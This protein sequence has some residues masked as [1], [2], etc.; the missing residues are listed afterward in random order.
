[1]KNI[2]DIDP[3]KITNFWNATIGERFPLREQLWNQ[4]TVTDPNILPQASFAVLDEDKLI[5]ILVSKKYQEQHQNLYMPTETGWIQCLLVDRE[6]RG[7]GIGTRLLSLAEKTFQELK[8]KDIKIGRDPQHYFPG[9]PFEDKESI[10]FFENKG[11]EKDSIEIDLYKRV[12]DQSLYELNHHESY[13]RLLS[14]HDHD[15]LLQFLQVSFP[16]RWH[17]EAARYFAQGGSGRE[18]LGLFVNG[19]MKGF[20]RLHDLDSPFIAANLYWSPLLEGKSGGIG[21][22]GVDRS[23]RGQNLGL[24]IVKAAANELIKRGMDHIIIDWTQLEQFYGKMG[25]RPWK[26][27]QSMSKRL[28]F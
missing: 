12:K 3:E 20:C 23:V 8:L 16:G 10:R 13:F 11:Y 14:S 26:R 19:E 28:H 17:Y 6:R 2:V 5:G 27:Y 4:N 22:L 1:M 7:E 9:I 15:S 18:I 21:P 24:D 25:F